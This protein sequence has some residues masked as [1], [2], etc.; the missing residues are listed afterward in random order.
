[1][2]DRSSGYVVAWSTLSL[3]L[4]RLIDLRACGLHRLHRLHSEAAVV[5]RVSAERV[6]RLLEALARVHETLVALMLADLAR[7]R[8]AHRHRRDRRAVLDLRPA[9]VSLVEGEGRGD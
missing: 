8:V 1:M 5:V 3:E 4:E 2:V 9:R 7:R 6:D